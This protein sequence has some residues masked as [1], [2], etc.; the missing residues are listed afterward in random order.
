MFQLE[1]WILLFQNVCILEEIRP[2]MNSSEADSLHNEFNANS[3]SRRNAH[4]RQRTPQ[5][6]STGA[7]PSPT[8]T[9][10]KVVQNG[11]YQKLISNSTTADAKLSRANVDLLP[12]PSFTPSTTVNNSGSYQRRKKTTSNSDNVLPSTDS[13][14][15][16]KGASYGSRD[17]SPDPDQ[18]SLDGSRDEVFVDDVDYAGGNNCVGMAREIE[19]K[20]HIRNGSTLSYEDEINSHAQGYGQKESFAHRLRKKSSS[21]T[22]DRPRNGKDYGVPRNLGHRNLTTDSIGCY[23]SINYGP[24]DNAK[25]PRRNSV[26]HEYVNVECID[27]I[28]QVKREANLPSSCDSI[29][30]LGTRDSFSPTKADFGFRKAPY[31]NVVAVHGGQF[32]QQK[33]PNPND[34]IYH[35]I[36]YTGAKRRT[37]TNSNRSGRSDEFVVAQ[38]QQGKVHLNYIDFS[39]ASDA[40]AQVARQQAINRSLEKKNPGCSNRSPSGTVKPNGTRVQPTVQYC[41]IDVESTNILHKCYDEHIKGRKEI[42]DRNH[43]RPP[44]ANS[45]YKSVENRHHSNSSAGSGG[46]LPRPGYR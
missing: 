5:H 2:S 23:S 39:P 15:P 19:A 29:S 12:A 26:K 4:N 46:S 34:S 27:N 41:A 7:S 18:L 32:R 37:E 40:A 45:T 24:Y 30:A 9:Q 25:Q 44:V 14:L 16:Y 28:F 35:S 31:E 11:N 17:V 3:G 33:P 42:Y 43:Q 1:N 10:T 38:P 20:V 6:S 36:S 21:K 22:T 13:S 8:S